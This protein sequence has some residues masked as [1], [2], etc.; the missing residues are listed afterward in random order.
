MTAATE[1]AKALS[2]RIAADNAIA[3]AK[4]QIRADEIDRQIA[5][6]GDPGG[7]WTR[8]AAVLRANAADNVGDVA[9]RVADGA[10]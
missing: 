4:M 8:M 5:K 2:E 1:S 3:K 6:H 9:F 7:H 10:R